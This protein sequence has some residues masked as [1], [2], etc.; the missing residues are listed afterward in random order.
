[1]FGLGGVDPQKLAEIQ[2]VSKDVRAEIRIDYGENAVRLFFS[3]ETPG[4]QALI[5]QLLD[6]FST[7]LA[8]QLSSFFAISGEIIEVGRD[9]GGQ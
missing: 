9:Q 4:G 8:S 7:A 6:Q 2:T 3:S 1:M 5:P